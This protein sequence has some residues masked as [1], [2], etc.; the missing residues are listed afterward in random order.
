MFRTVRDAGPTVLVPLAW[1]VVASAHRGV[2]S[3]TAVFVAHLVMA[4]FITAFAVTGWSEMETG[5]LRGWRAVLV[6]GLFVTLAGV[7]GFVFSLQPLLGLSLVG[8]MV[9]PAAGLLYTGYLF[10]DARSV[11]YSSGVLSTVGAAVYVVSLADT[12]PVLSLVGIALVGLGQTIG[13]VDASIRS[14]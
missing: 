5:A 8:W 11:Y 7:A 1:L 6:V 2:V 3:E 12:G 13:I 4:G 9:L 14:Q 10:T